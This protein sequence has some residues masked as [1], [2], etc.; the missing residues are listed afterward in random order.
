MLISRFSKSISKLLKTVRFPISS[1]FGERTVARTRWQM[2]E[3]NVKKKKPPNIQGNS[4]VLASPARLERAAFRLGVTM[5]VCRSALWRRT[6]SLKPLMLRGFWRSRFPHSP[7]R[8]H[9]IRSVWCALVSNGLAER[10]SNG[11]CTTHIQGRI[12]PVST[13]N[14]WQRK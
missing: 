9:G 1:F 8:Y 11:K 12:Y 4:V 7:M 3:R 10:C 13:E 14:T 5:S 6:C 2:G